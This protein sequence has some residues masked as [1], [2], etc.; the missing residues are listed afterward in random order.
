[1]REDRAHSDEECDIFKKACDYLGYIWRHYGLSVTPKFH[2]LECHAPIYLCEY[3]RFFGEDGIERLHASNNRHNRTLQGVKRFHDKINL[4]EKRKTSDDLPDV[5]TANDQIEANT[6][7]KLSEEFINK[8]KQKHN[9]RDQ[10]K[11]KRRGNVKYLIIQLV[12]LF[13]FKNI[14]LFFRNF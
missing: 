13:S 8:K 2:H 4:R 14:Y 1:M 12:S 9:E 7:R 11:L 3:Q 10:N 6:S 5:Q